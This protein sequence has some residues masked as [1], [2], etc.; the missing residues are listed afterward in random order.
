MRVAAPNL[1]TGNTLIVKHAPNV[2]QCALA[3]E[4]LFLDAGAPVGAY[5]NVFLS[6][7][8]AAL[9]SGMCESGE[10]L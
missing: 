5:T 7:E 10:S 3:F 1:M 4:K 8:Q 6:N 2:P 9:A